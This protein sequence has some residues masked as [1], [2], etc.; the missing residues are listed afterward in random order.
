MPA[1]LT[2]AREALADHLLPRCNVDM[3]GGQ[4]EDGPI[5]GCPC[6][7]HIDHDG[8]HYAPEDGPTWEHLRDALARV[9]ELEQARARDVAGIVG[10]LRRS[11]DRLSGN[12][13]REYVLIATAIERGDWH[14]HE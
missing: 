3:P 5:P 4:D 6:D 9:D 14:D 11:A 8:E 2:Q 12:D 13:Y 7:R 1:D 10:W